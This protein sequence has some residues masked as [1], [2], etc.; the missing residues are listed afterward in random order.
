MSNI[1]SSAIGQRIKLRRKELGLTQSQV[2]ELV[3]KSIN[4][5][6]AIE[7][8][9]QNPSLSLIIDLCDI[10]KTT[11]DYLLL[12]NTHG[13][14]ISSDIIDS[15]QLCTPEYLEIIKMIIGV[16]VESSSDSWTSKNYIDLPK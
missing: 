6:S 4:H 1:N 9:S 7:N 15:L 13:N 3:N 11:P 14:N 8:G 10:L 5:I 12:G 16:F 2:S